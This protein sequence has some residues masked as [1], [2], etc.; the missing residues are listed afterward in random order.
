MGRPTTRPSPPPIP[1]QIPSSLPLN[2]LQDFGELLRG[3]L[4]RPSARGDVVKE[5]LHGDGGAGH[6]GARARGALLQV[7]VAVRG[8]EGVRRIRRH[9]GHREVGPVVSRADSL[10][11]KASL[12][13]TASRVIGGARQNR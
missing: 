4:E 1:P 2:H 8:F 7:S 13:V 3:R 6:S 5:V 11:L 12:E 10:G 9:G